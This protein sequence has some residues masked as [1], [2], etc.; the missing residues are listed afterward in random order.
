M[1]TIITLFTA[2]LPTY[3]STAADFLCHIYLDTTQSIDA[4]PL[5]YDIRRCFYELLMNIALKKSL[6]LS[7]TALP[8]LVPI[9]L[10]VTQCSTTVTII[11]TALIVTIISSISK[12]QVKSLSGHH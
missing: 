5:L 11:V 1:V 2:F 3:I 10:Y 6:H 7:L 9:C 4:L 12:C 8:F